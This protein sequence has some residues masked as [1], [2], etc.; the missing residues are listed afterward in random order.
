MVVV[1]RWWP[2]VLLL[3]HCQGCFADGDFLA[4]GVDWLRR[5]PRHLSIGVAMAVGT[6]T[7]SRSDIVTREKLGRM[8]Q[9]M[10][11]EL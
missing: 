2:S 8:H 10:S 11:L 4:M 5:Q 1:Y 9:N 6:Y 3:V 7:C